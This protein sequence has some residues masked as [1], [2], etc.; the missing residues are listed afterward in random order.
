MKNTLRS[1][2]LI[3]ND[4]YFSY[5]SNGNHLNKVDVTHW[6][7]EKKVVKGDIIID[8]VPYRF[9]GKGENLIKQVKRIITPLISEYHFENEF[10]HLKVSFWS[11]AFLDDPVR[12]SRPTSYIDFE[13][14]E[15]DGKHHD[16][17]IQVSFD[18]SFT[19]DVKRDSDIN[20]ANIAFDKYD[21]AFLGKRKQP[22]LEASGD[23]LR[24]NWGYLFLSILKDD[25]K[26]AYVDDRRSSLVANI[27]SKKATLIVA[28]DDIAS[29][30]Y[31]G[32]ITY[33]YWKKEYKDVKEAIVASFNDHDKCLEKARKLDKEIIKVAKKSGGNPLVT[34]VTASYRQSIAGHKTSFDENGDLIFI[35]KECFS[36][37]CAATVDVSYPSI[38]LY[39]LYNPEFVFG[40]VR[41]II[42]CARLPYW[43][44][45]F[46]PHDGGRYPHVY[47]N[48]YGIED[49]D[50]HNK[51]EN[52][53]S[54]PP[55]YLFSANEKLF[56]D[57]RHM[58]VEECGNMLIMIAV[59]SLKS[60]DLTIAKENMDLLTKWTQYL[61]KFG[62][63]P[64]NQLCTDDF[65][66]HLAHN[67]NLAVKSILGIEA[68]AQ[69]N[70]MI[71]N[72]E[73]Y[74]KYHLLA[75][76]FAKDWEKKTVEGDHTILVFDKRDGWS[77]KYNLIWDDYFKSELFSKELKENEVDWYIK[78]ANKFGTPLDCRADYTKSDW[79]TWTTCLTSDIDKRIKLLKPLELFINTSKDRVPF[80]DWY[81]TKTGRK[82][83]FQARTVQG[84]C[85]API[86]LDSV[87]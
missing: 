20:G 49:R 55:Y 29:L 37:G 38:P 45:D 81:E 30:N 86:L 46:S 12:L 77:L 16:I 42:K 59:A 78:K 62:Q 3:T 58:P 39:V 1:Y 48:V 74:K 83:Y 13:V 54:Y 56:R 50:P 84:G 4:P 18:E 7:G 64:G 69:I 52:N 65:A 63:D 67:T 61:V 53:N 8:N 14:E 70:K 57:D 68:Y 9:L 6:T 19:Y 87:K 40:M 24:I 73:E 21:I 35:S 47:G 72:E 27:T 28:Y 32:Q 11:P 75:K 66:G 10:V 80:G 60:K 2:P 17:S 33:G 31:Y 43:T 15:L 23:N 51:S 41:P 25:G 34:I 26:V 71:G 79:L 36:N 85:F 44:F 22:L 5:W 82:I 76:D